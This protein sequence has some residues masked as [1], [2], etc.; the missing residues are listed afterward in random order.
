MVKI[1][2]LD[3]KKNLQKYKYYLL[4][5]VM[6]LILTGVFQAQIRQIGTFLFGV[7]I[8]RTIDLLN[9]KES[10]NILLLGIAGGGHDGPKLTDT[11]ILANV[12]IDQNKVHMFSVPRDL[13]VPPLERKI[14]SVYAIGEK[15]GKGIELSR[16]AIEDLTGQKVD[17]VLVL[18][19]Q[20]FT[21]II[22][23]LGGIDV[24]VENSFIDKQY[25]ITGKEEDICGKSEE[26]FEAL[27][28]A[29]SQLDA[30]PCRYK[31]IAFER[32]IQ[33]MNGET[34]LEFVRS[35][36]GTNGEGSDFARSKRQQ[37]II[38]ALREKVF[39]LG[40]ILNPVKLLGI[41][42]ILTDN[43]NTD[44]DT[45]K[46]DDFV[47]LA[48]KMKDGQIKSYVI[49]DGNK[50]DERWGLFI[51][52]PISKDYGFQYVLIPRK[53]VGNYSEIHEYVQCIMDGKDCLIGQEQLIIETITP[54]SAKEDVA[55]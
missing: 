37:V 29:A 55:N 27:A 20:G 33:K 11:I 19:F 1:R 18:D 10:F 46:I 42:N 3:S 21:K 6:V 39:S 7:T 22:D 17:Y 50:A 12:N 5:G 52:P 9:K 48:D 54:S 23:Y 28:T 45:E 14:N 43:I 4:A 8:D 36:H 15:E 24:R 41:Y 30:F 31:T 44:I 38:A 2:R 34:A 35:R 51:N 32:G 16:S 49:D 47:K 13:W 53:G 26:E 40:V 25:P